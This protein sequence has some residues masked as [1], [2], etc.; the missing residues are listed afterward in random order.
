MG[1]CYKMCV[2][3]RHGK[4]RRRS[5]GDVLEGKKSRL[6]DRVYWKWKRHEGRD[7][8]RRRRIDEDG[9]D[10]WERGGGERN[11]GESGARMSRRRKSE[12]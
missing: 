3:F 11:G 6:R 2:R 1:L 8:R 10:D 12:K 7:G 9:G 5:R 4:M